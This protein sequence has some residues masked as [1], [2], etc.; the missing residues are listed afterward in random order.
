M[1]THTHTH[2]HTARRPLRRELHHRMQHSSHSGKHQ[3]DTAHAVWTES[4][5]GERGQPTSQPRPTSRFSFFSL[6]PF[7]SHRSHCLTRDSLAWRVLLLLRHDGESRRDL[8]GPT[9][10]ASFLIAR[11]ITA[12]ACHR[13]AL[14]VFLI[15]GR[16]EQTDRGLAAAGET[17]PRARSFRHRHSE[18]TGRASSWNPRHV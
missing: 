16:K 7:S 3:T 17:Q 14:L 11:E 13:R 5:N 12:T 15:P 2:T 8:V 9:L 10:G 4:R 18:A 6:H 1:H